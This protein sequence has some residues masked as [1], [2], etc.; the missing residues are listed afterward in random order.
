MDNQPSLRGAEGDEAI[1]KLNIDTPVC[2]SELVSE[3]IAELKDYV[4]R[5][6]DAKEHYDFTWRGKAAAIAEAAMPVNKILR[7]DP[8][9]SIDFN[10]TENLYIEGDNLDA[11]KLLQ[12]SYLGAVKMIYIDP[13]YN[14]GKD[15][16][17]HDNFHQ[18]AEEYDE[19]TGRIDAEGNKNFKKNDKTNGRFH[20][21]W[22]SMMLPRLK[23]ARNLL[24]D[25]GVIFIS[26]DDNEQANLKLL[27]DEVFGEENFLATISVVNNLKGRSDDEF[28]ATAS[29]YMLCYARKID[30]AVINGFELPENMQEEY[31]FN[32]GISRY[33]EVSLQKTGKSN[34]RIDRPNMYYEI[35]YNP[36]TKEFFDKPESGALAILPTPINGVDGRWRWGKDTFRKNKDTELVARQVG[37]N[38]RVYVKM[39]DVVNGEQRKLKPKTVWIDPKYDTGNGG[40]EVKNLFGIANLF[41]NPKSVDFLKDAIT[42]G[43]DK[44]AIICDFFSGSGTTAHAV[45]KLNTEDGGNRKFILVQLPEETPENSEAKKAGYATIP[46]I[47]R[48]RIKRAGEKI[49][50]ENP[51]WHGDAGFRRLVIDSTNIKDN[52]FEPATTENQ[53]SLLDKVENTKPD[54]TDLDLLFGV[55]TAVALP[56]GKKLET[57]SAN[58]TPY[59]LYDHDGE[60]TGVL[61]CFAPTLSRETIEEFAR[62]KPNLAVFRESTFPDSASKIN[63]T[64]IFKN[65][66]PDTKVRVI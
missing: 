20:S 4:E 39:R 3:S 65:L 58:D 32:D 18:T 17:Y 52:I 38:W 10:N 2:H 23:L 27:C 19:E 21:D 41:E 55:L 24:M 22:L 7:P 28:Y 47:A 16:V 49:T 35:Y 6:E 9:N 5:A 31:K 66:S 60:L 26:I 40:R 63:L 37:E 30:Q 64:Q 12:E 43:S 29:E 57:A 42:A 14:T 44:D 13:P 48:E 45:M 33:K 53:A 15:F 54:R 25:D 50:T 51:D 1:Q 62:L 59:Y 8:E 36:E 61:A 46:E 56:L 11:L 34:R